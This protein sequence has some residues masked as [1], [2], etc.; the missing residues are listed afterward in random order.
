MASGDTLLVFTPQCNE[1][2]TANFATFDVRNQHPVLDFALNAIGIFSSVMP[3][4][5]GGGGVTV[6][7]H[8]AMTSA[9]ADDIKLE[10]SFEQIGDQQQDIDDDGF[11]AAQNTG[12]ITVPGTSGNVDIIPSTHTDGEQMDSIAV[13]EGFRLKVKRIAVAGDDASGD[14]EL[15]FIEI[16][17]T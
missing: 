7:L 1:P 14:L 12:D 10:T 17:E 15:R 9:V 13:G 11:A 2:P 3:R 4:H 6:Y 8:Y 16:K 5:Y